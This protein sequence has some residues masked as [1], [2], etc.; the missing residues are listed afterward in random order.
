MCE[1][2]QGS[3]AAPLYGVSFGNG[4][5][6]VSRMF[7]NYYV[8]TTEPFVLAHAAMLAEFKPKGRAWC[9]KH[10]EIDGDSEYGIT[11]VLD[12]PPCEDTDDGE[13]PELT[14]DNGAVIEWEDC[15]DGRN[16]SYGNGAWMLCEVFRVEEGVDTRNQPVYDSLD[17]ALSADVVALAR[18]A[19]SIGE[20]LVS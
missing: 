8:R 2:E 7:A 4:I 17:D 13:Y 3:D 1:V 16:W 20:A 19:D 9:D 11:A 14:D 12:N 10:V 6:G 18:R 5:N 15:E